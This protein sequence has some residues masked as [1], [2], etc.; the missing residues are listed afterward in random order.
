[1]IR[2]QKGLRARIREMGSFT[3]LVKGANDPVAAAEGLRAAIARMLEGDEEQVVVKFASVAQT[4]DGPTAYVDAP[5]MDPEDAERLIGAINKE[6]ER[7]GV[8]AGTLRLAPQ[9]ESPDLSAF[10]PSAIMRTYAPRLRKP[11]PREV[12]LPEPWRA[13][14]LDWLFGDGS[15]GVAYVWRAFAGFTVPVSGIESLVSEAWN[16]STQI[17]VGDPVRRIRGASFFISMRPEMVLGFG[18]T[19]VSDQEL[20][21]VV[22]ELQQ[23]ARA[24]APHVEYA[25]VDHD[26]GSLHNLGQSEHISAREAADQVC[27]HNLMDRSVL[28]AFPYQILSSSQFQMLTDVSATRVAE[29]KYEIRFGEP[30]DWLMSDRERLRRTREQ[31]RSAMAPLLLTPEEAERIMHE[32]WLLARFDPPD[33]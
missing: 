9:V 23:M 16:L 11:Y 19:E 10:G 5:D 15:S 26:I 32:N 21:R 30:I 4:P 18:G 24:L 1:M 14:F 27:L 8:R 31:A 6:L 25:F 7:A 22:K 3:L 12:T 13:H 28:D 33:P 17:V 29:D 2:E 20:L